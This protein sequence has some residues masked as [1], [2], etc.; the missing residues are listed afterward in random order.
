MKLKIRYCFI[1][2]FAIGINF[3]AQDKQPLRSG[4]PLKSITPDNI[5]VF[6]PPGIH[7]IPI[8]TVYLK[9]RDMPTLFLAG[10][11]RYP[12]VY[13]YDCVKY[14]DNVPVFGEPSKVSMPSRLGDLLPGSLVEY[15]N[16]VY[17]YWLKRDTVFE[18]LYNEKNN[19]FN[20]ARH[21]VLK[22]L[23]RRA[24]NIQVTLVGNKLEGVIDVGDGVSSNGPVHWVKEKNFAA[25]GPDGI[26]VGNLTYTGLYGFSTSFFQPE[27]EVSTKALTGMKEV[28]W[29]YLKVSRISYNENQQ[30]LL[31][32]SVNG[33]FLYYSIGKDIFSLE[34]KRLAVDENDIAIR[35]TTIG[36]RPVSLSDKHGK[37]IGL[38][39][40][41][42]GGLFFY[43]FIRISEKQVPVYGNALDLLAVNPDLY[44]GSLV[45]PNLIDWNNDGKLDLIV[46]NSA[47]HILYYEN[48][49]S[50]S[51]PVFGIP[52]KLY[53]GN[54]LIHIQPGYNDDIQG[55]Y[56]SRW[57]YASPTVVDWNNDGLLD[58]LT[59]DSRGK[60]RL[61]LNVGTRTESR[62]A[63][64]AP[65]YLDGLELHGTW[66]TRPGVAKMGDRMA[67]ITQDA[68]DQFHIYWQ[69]DTYN[70]IDG[71]KLRLEDGSYIDGSYFPNGGGSGRNK[72]LIVD[73]DGDGIKDLLIG[74]PRHGSVP[75]RDAGM[76]YY[77]GDKGASVLFMK[78]MGT[79]ESPIFAYP[80][81]IKYKGESVHFGQHECAP[82]VGNM[83]ISDGLDLLV[84][85]ETGRFIFFERFDLTW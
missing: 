33:N 22:Q 45:V 79:E 74:T 20:V 10:D 64:E 66:R 35:H 18:T 51:N 80:K 50:N 14:K 42:E 23:P 73:W 29:D 13:R 6:S 8:G 40:G 57:G 54:E 61:F 24:K 69:L 41:G 11:G 4:F 9:N 31:T 44:G 71:G 62:L 49:G 72:F 75:K 47:G 46:G 48:R 32:G 39:V 78:N 65:I 5:G 34:D 38:I 12:G 52:E 28:M 58:I 43:P 84:G 55:P 83:G 67:Y 68:Q 63:E 81:M 85:T 21:I 60:H 3:Y 37:H 56:E 36:A 1:L 17:A 82:S 15:K 19:S 7:A 59:N 26:F 77:Y 27:P 70:L 2:L 53:A 25:Y 76:P 16:E 30:G